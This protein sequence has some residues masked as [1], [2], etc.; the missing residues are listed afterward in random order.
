MDLTAVGKTF[1]PY[2]FRV[3]RGKIREF[4]NAIGDANPIYRDLDYAALCAELP[5]N[6]EPAFDGMSFR[7][8]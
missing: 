3:E 4:A 2:E 1:P 6:V 7:A 5:E 8:D